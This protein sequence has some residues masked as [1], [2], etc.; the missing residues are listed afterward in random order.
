M[1]LGCVPEGD[2]FC[3]ACVEA[4]CVEVAPSVEV[5]CECTSVDDAP[6]PK[7]APTIAPDAA[8][9]TAPDAAFAV[10]PD[11]APNAA[12][13]AALERGAQEAAKPTRRTRRAR[14]LGEM[15]N[16]Y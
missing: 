5:G 6:T 3:P 14:A 7:L 12:P 4:G 9:D 2:W 16:A 15:T 10:G 11:T 1:P 13:D 8:P